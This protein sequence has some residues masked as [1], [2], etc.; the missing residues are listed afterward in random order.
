MYMKILVCALER[1][2]QKHDITQRHTA[3]FKYALD[4]QPKN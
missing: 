3:Y 4:Q 2:T 1:Q